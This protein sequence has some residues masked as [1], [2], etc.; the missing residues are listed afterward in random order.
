M[1]VELRAWDFPTGGL[2]PSDLLENVPVYSE[3]LLNKQVDCVLLGVSGA[4][5]FVAFKRAICPSAHTPCPC[6]GFSFL[7]LDSTAGSARFA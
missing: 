4:W 6:G 7:R 1:S 3:A 5:W 2:P